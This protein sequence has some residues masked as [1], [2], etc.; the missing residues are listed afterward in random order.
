MLPLHQE[1]RGGGAESAEYRCGVFSARTFNSTLTHPSIR[2]HSNHPWGTCLV[3]LLGQ[4]ALPRTGMG[5]ATTS[6]FCKL[7]VDTSHQAFDLLRLPHQAVRLP[8]ASSEGIHES[9]THSTS[10]ASLSPS[11]KVS[12]QTHY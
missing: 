1:R 2:A 5:C 7:L 6:R 8:G 10:V 11:P 12:S 9:F 3:S 4:V